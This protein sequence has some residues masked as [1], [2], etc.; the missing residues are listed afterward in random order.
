MAQRPCFPDL[1]P[2]YRLADAAAGAM[3]RSLGLPPD[4]RDDLRQDL[5][6][7]LLT[8]LPSYDAARGE[9]GAFARVCIRHAATRLARKAKRDR[10]ARHPNGLDDPLPGQEGVTVGAGVSEGEGYSAWCG[11]PTDAVAAL[12]RRLDLE[13][14]GAA[15]DAGDLPLCGALSRQTPHELGKG[16]TIPRARI[17]R[18]ITEMRL[19]LLAAGV[20]SAA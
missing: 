4:E 7:D 20:T 8:R 18:R 14:A 15:I 6:V 12:E 1:T 13:R 19:R 17:Y 3:C 16:G 5:L 2:A 11:Q 10:A 9:F